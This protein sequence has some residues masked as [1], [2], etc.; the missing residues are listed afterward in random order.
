MGPAAP[1]GPAGVSGT[2]CALL[3]TAQVEGGVGDAEQGQGQE[4]DALGHEQDHVE[5]EQEGR[6]ARGMML[7][8]LYLILFFTQG[9]ALIVLTLFGLA[10][11]ALN[12]R[13]RPDGAT[14]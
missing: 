5:A 10:D 6:P 13:R 2:A 4:G 14:P 1:S 11:T 3:G 8:G 12:R 9:I 7:F